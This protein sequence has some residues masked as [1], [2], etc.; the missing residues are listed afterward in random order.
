[1]SQKS[2]LRF[3]NGKMIFYFDGELIFL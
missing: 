2:T 3:I 1:M